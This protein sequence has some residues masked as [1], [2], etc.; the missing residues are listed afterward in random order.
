MRLNG[1]DYT[2]PELDFDAMCEL[3]ERGVYLLGMDEKNPKFATMI[4][5]FV[6]WVLDVPEKEASHEIQEHILSGGSLV[7]ILEDITRAAEKGGFFKK[8]GQNRNQ[9]NPKRPQDFQKK[10]NQYQNRPNQNYRRNTQQ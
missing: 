1:R 6:A 8:S 7:Q 4:R 2:I 3:E 10:K 9:Q 5:G